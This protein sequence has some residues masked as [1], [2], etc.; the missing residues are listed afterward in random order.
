MRRR[1][2]LARVG[3]LAASTAASTLAL[4]GCL[5]DGPATDGSDRTG[6]TEPTDSTDP[7]ESTDSTREG[8]AEPPNPYAF[9]RCERFIVR[10]ET[11]P[12]VGREEVD[13]ALAEGYYETTDE[14]YVPHLFDV[15]ES[16]LRVDGDHYRV[17]VRDDGDVARIELTE[18]IPT[19]GAVSFG[20]TNEG[21][22]SVDAA[23]RVTRQRDGEVVV[24]D[25]A[26]VAA[27]E[28]AMLGSAF[29]R[30]FGEYVATVETERVTETVRWEERE[31]SLPARGVIVDGDEVYVE[32]GP[33]LEPVDCSVAW[34]LD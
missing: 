15:D 34:D 3:T 1:H 24:D 23:V 27:G 18:T 30:T 4:A 25:S 28:G 16:F 8:T 7:T 29:D 12:A 20:I 33:V 10:Y 2:V 9:E 17:S 11:L 19:R 13:V 22:E 31:L 5:S 26:T 32:P 21:S 6:T 14:P